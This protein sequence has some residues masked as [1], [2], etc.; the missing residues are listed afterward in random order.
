MATMK[1]TPALLRQACEI[2]EESLAETGDDKAAQRFVEL[3]EELDSLIHHYGA[4]LQDAIDST[5]DMLG[6]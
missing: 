2:L 5:M 1:L 6:R 4:E 3:G